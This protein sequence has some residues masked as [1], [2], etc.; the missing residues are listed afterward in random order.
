[1]TLDNSGTKFMWASFTRFVW[2]ALKKPLDLDQWAEIRK[3]ANS[4]TNS[5]GNCHGKLTLQESTGM[6]STIKLFEAFK[7]VF[8]SQAV[9]MLTRMTRVTRFSSNQL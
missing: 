9:R 6:D 7:D 8:I 4:E 2:E 5:E 1:M 3:V